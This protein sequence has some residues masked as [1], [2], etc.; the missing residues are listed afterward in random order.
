MDTDSCL[1]DNDDNMFRM[2]EKRT[3]KNGTEQEVVERRLSSLQLDLSIQDIG[4]KDLKKKLLEFERKLEKVENHLTRL[5]NE[6]DKLRKSVA[7]IE[8]ARDL[9]RH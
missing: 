6:R 4:M 7:T 8:F 2:L 5:T 3:K 9:L 1:S